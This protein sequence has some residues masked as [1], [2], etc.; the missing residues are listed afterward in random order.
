MAMYKKII[1]EFYPEFEFL[2]K[3]DGL[4]SNKI[5]VQLIHSKRSLKLYRTARF[6]KSKYNYHFFTTNIKK[7]KIPGRYLLIIK[8]CYNKKGYSIGKKP[9]A[10]I[11]PAIILDGKFLGHGKILNYR[12]FK[13]IFD[14]LNSI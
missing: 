3:K 5:E 10:L 1:L 11:S 12:E 4:L 9:S 6:L 7:N 13:L 14:E 2:R 8:K